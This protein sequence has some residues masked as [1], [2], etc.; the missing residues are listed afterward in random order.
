MIISEVVDVLIRVINAR[1]DKQLQ[2]TIY[3]IFIQK[4]IKLTYVGKKCVLIYL[5]K[6]FVQFK[7]NKFSWK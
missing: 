2:A 1:E 3:F 4:I 7:N 5:R 6:Y